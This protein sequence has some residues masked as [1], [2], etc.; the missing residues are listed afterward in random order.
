MKKRR[1]IPLIL[2][3][4]MMACGDSNQTEIDDDAMIE[5]FDVSKLLADAT[6]TI[7]LPVLADFNQE[8]VTF[9]EM[10]VAYTNAPSENGFTALRSQWTTMAISYERTYVFH[11]GLARERFLHNAIYSWPTVVSAVEGFIEDDIINEE[12]VAAI[13]PQIKALAGLEYLLFKSDAA[14]THQE[15]LND[16]KRTELLRLSSEFILAQ[17]NRLF[18]IW[19]PNDEAYATTFINNETTGVRASFNLFFNGL[20]NAIDVAKVSKIG[21]PGGFESSSAANAA[22]VQAP[23][24]G[25]S[26]DLLAANI[27][28]VEEAFFAEN[29]TNIS[30]YI[31]FTLKDNSL[32]EDI[33]SKI[34]EIQATISIIDAPLTEAVINNQT[35]VE[36]LHTQLTELRILFTVDVRSTLSLIVTATDNDGD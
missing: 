22:I 20:N 17:A 8:A 26:L 35:Q 6:N 36:N 7:I 5:E 10:V 25:T 23:F 1:I 4:L 16:A 9:N 12:T 13:S 15:F 24:S 11:I 18:S 32:N 29:N 27:A 28:M 31:F 14:T 2:V 30:D 34:N 33:Q 21:K 19:D 3:L